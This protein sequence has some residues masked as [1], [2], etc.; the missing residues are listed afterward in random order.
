MVKSKKG[1]AKAIAE[2]RPWANTAKAST[3]GYVMEV[4]QKPVDNLEEC[5]TCCHLARALRACPASRGRPVTIWPGS[6]RTSRRASTC[7]GP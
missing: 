6:K 4:G 5:L 2:A 7:R 1:K 3:K